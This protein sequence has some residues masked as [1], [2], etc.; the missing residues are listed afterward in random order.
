MRKL[1]VKKSWKWLLIVLVVC[2]VIGVIMFKPQKN[3]D[4]I[5]KMIFI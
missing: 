3:I 2:V 5:L 1:S 4:T